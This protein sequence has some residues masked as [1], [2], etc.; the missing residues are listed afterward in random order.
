MKAIHDVCPSGVDYGFETPNHMHTSPDHNDANKLQTF[1]A[2][3]Q[4]RKS[5][6]RISNHCS[7]WI[8][9]QT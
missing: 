5:K 4:V 9:L 2:G 1:D 8:L 7:T 3:K 6:D